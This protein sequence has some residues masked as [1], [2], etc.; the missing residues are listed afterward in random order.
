MKKEDDTRTMAGP[1]APIGIS[2]GRVGRQVLA[3]LLAVAVIIVF[4]EYLR[5]FVR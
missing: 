1:K 2:W 3:F 5:T 4:L